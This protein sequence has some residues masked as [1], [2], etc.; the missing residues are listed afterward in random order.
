MPPPNPVHAV[1]DGTTPPI[2][3]SSDA[4]Q[5]HERAHPVTSHG[6]RSQSAFRD[7]SFS[8]PVLRLVAFSILPGFRF[9]VRLPFVQQFLLSLALSFD[10]RGLVDVGCYRF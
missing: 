6:L 9:P 8:L 4:S 7:K 1:S 5:V 2:N 10:L 3:V